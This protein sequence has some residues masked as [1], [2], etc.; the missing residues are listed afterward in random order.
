MKRNPKK[1]TEQ[2]RAKKAIKIH[3]RKIN[4]HK[5][6]NNTVKIKRKKIHQKRINSMRIHSDTLL[7]K[8]L[9]DR[10]IDR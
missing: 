6:Y 8:Y 4:V 2:K 7:L 10:L 9:S 1:K 3:N 5:N